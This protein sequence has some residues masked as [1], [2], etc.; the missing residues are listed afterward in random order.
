PLQR[1]RVLAD[2][3]V[4]THLRKTGEALMEAI[5]RSSR[6]YRVPAAV[7]GQGSMFQV[8][9]S[10]SGKPTTQYRD[11]LSADAKR[12]AAFRQSLLEQ[13]VHCNSSGLACWFIS[14]AHTSEDVEYTAAAIDRAM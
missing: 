5:R 11:T 10:E 1:L 8:V 2:P 7:Q 9:F 13:G 3:S 12:Y 6:N 4:G 14:A